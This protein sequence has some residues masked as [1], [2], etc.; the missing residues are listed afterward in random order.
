MLLG[1]RKKKKAKQERTGTS[2]KQG[3]LDESG[4]TS[5]GRQNPKGMKTKKPGGRKICTNIKDFSLPVKKGRV[6][7]E[8]AR[9]RQT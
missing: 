3:G 8:K 1:F 4:S 5:E 2:F 9:T 6:F 7:V